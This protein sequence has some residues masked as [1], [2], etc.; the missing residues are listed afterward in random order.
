MTDQT[1]CAKS[2]DCK[3]TDCPKHLNGFNGQYISLAEF[4]C[5]EELGDKD[6]NRG[7]TK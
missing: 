1:Y 5:D 3:H 6:D 4:D 7:I 2:N